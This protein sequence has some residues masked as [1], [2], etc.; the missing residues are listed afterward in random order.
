MHHS[1]AI[2]VSEFVKGNDEVGRY[3]FFCFVSFGNRSDFWETLE[4]MQKVRLRMSVARSNLKGSGARGWCRGSIASKVSF[5]PLVGQECAEKGS[6]LQ[7]TKFTVLVSL[8]EVDSYSRSTRRVLL[9][10]FSCCFSQ[11]SSHEP[12]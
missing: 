11:N 2:V 6:Q 3:F 1:S 5:N 12:R 10:P 7:N 8:F 4:A 9:E